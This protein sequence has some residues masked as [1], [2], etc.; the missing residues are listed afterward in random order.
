MTHQKG[1]ALFLILI[2][3]A[4]FAAL[5]YAVTQSGRGGGAID[6]ETMLIKAAQATQQ[7]AY[8]RTAVTRMI[9]TNGTTPSTLDLHTGDHKTPCSTGANCLFSPTGGGVAPPTVDPYLVDAST[10]GSP[11]L[12]TYF[13]GTHSVVGVGTSAPDP[14]IV[15]E[16]LKKEACLAINRG[17]GIS[18]IPVEIT[19]HYI[20]FNFGDSLPGKADACVDVVG[21]LYNYV[22]YTALAEN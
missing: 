4:L 10:Q 18:G 5:S 2:A 21:S 1:N 19:P 20:D 14:I 6:K 16:S 9:L 11:P 17:L 15:F 8:L 13:E 3:V 12:V 22:Y 7:K